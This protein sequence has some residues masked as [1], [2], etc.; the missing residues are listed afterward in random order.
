MDAAPLSAEA[1]FFAGTESLQAGDMAGAETRLRQALQLAPTLAEAHA[2]L[3]LVLEARGALPE[4]VACYQLSIEHNPTL[5]QTYI[6]LA[7]A[8]ILLRQLDAAEVACAQALR[9]EHANP[10]A[11]CNLGVAYARMGLEL[12]AEESC[13]E[14]LVLQPGHAKALFNLAYLLLRQGRWEEGWA[15]FEARDW[16]AYLARHVDCPRWLGEP[17]AGRSVLV[18]YEA[19]QGD[20]LQFCR[21]VAALKAR[22]AGAI[23]LLC[24][25]PLKRLLA[26][27]AGVD[28]IV[29]FDEALPVAGWDCWT[30]LMSLPYLSQTRVDSIPA[31]LPYLHAEPALLAAWAPRLPATGLR[32]GLVWKGS[33]GFE[34]DAERSLPSLAALLPLAAVNGVSFISLQKGAGEDQAAQPPAGLQLTALG[35]QLRDF[36]DTAAVIEQLDLLISVDTAVAHLAGALGK[37]CWVLLPDYLTDWRWLEER[38]DSPWYPGVMRLFRQPAGGGWAPVVADVAAALEAF[39]A[40]RLGGAGHHG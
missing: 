36:A 4:A 15:C 20:M 30:P 13:R 19:G 7:G 6:N 17:L 1:L 31:V 29:G 5:A 37:P 3:G 11:W 28:H 38:T 12:E 26:S 40:R 34:N 8:L 14:A 22:G 10:D 21:Y 33:T 25:P 9:L 2:N 23:T 32:V 27:L 24:H 39:A 35:A 16:Y 18:G